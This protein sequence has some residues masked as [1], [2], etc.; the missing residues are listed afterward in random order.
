MFM[1]HST[2]LELLLGEANESLSVDCHAVPTW[3][4][5]GFY[6]D[7]DGHTAAKRMMESDARAA[8][9][10]ALAYR[11]TG[12]AA[13]A[14]KA[15]ELI[16]G[17]A[18][19]N[20]EITG[21][22]G[23]LVS[24]YLGVGLILAAEWIKEFS[25]WSKEEQDQYIRWMTQVCLPEWD[26]IP[27][28]NNWWNWSLY[29][30]LALFRFMDDKAR[31]SEEVTA[32]KEHLD[33]SLSL[34]GFIPEET[35]RGKHS[36]WYHYF[37]LAP[38]TA[39]AK[40]ILDTTGEDLFHW[41]SPGGKSLKTALDRFFHYTDGRLK[42]WPYDDDPIFPA[43]LS[44]DTWPLDLFEAMSKVYKSP[45]YERFVSPYRPIT[46]NTNKNSGYYQSYTWIYPELQLGI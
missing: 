35:H 45:D 25:D 41:V 23:P 15:K 7:A 8:Y 31:F 11:L 9:T 2:A 30:Q 34:E 37:A 28:R 36:L 27:L 17:W 43:P 4:I 39:A 40:L 20:Q 10:T 46:G 3:N 44:A 16:M 21:P 24:A 6:W 5:P 26:R 22:D 32:F 29:A 14:S 42:E 38:A 12:T 19:V 33:S 18:A 13:Y 1:K